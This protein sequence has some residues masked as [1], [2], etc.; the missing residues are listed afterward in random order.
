MPLAVSRDAGSARVVVS[1]ALDRTVADRVGPVVGRLAGEGVRDVAV[2]LG[3]LERFDS[4]ALADLAEAVRA[5]RAAGATLRIERAPRAFRETF[6]LVPIDA[7]L[8]GAES[9]AA[10]GFVERAGRAAL[11]V[12]RS[13]REQFRLVVETFHCT[14]I[15]PFRGAGPR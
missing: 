14:A 5:A 3:G 1:G 2:D 8:A 10:P 15:A 11:P 13:I 7:L 12:V 9:P 6:S 4:V